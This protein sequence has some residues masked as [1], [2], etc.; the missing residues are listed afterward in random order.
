ML[1]INEL[2]SM[3]QFS[4][5]HLCGPGVIIYIELDPTAINFELLPELVRVSVFNDIINPRGMD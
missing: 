2:V 5:R 1:I 4:F 3:D